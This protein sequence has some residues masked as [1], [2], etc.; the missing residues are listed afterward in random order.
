MKVVDL[1]KSLEYKT[2]DEI[3]KEILEVVEIKISNM[4]FCFADF[5]CNDCF[6]NWNR[7]LTEQEEIELPDEQCPNCQGFNVT[8]YK[9]Y[10]KA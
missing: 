4:V 10:H 8:I 3:E 9:Q 5:F 6:A 1:Q 7:E 2:L